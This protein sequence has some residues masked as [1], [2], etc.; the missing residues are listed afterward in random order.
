MTVCLSMVANSVDETTSQSIR[1]LFDFGSIDDLNSYCAKMLSALPYQ[2]RDCRLTTANSVWINSKINPSDGFVVDMGNSFSAP[3][4]IMNDDTSAAADEINR[5]CYDKTAGLIPSIVNASD[6]NACKA[7]IANA[8]YFNAK[9]NDPF[10]PEKTKSETFHGI[11][12]DAVVDMMH[13]SITGGYYKSDT[14]ESAVISY[15]DNAYSMIAVMPLPGNSLA[16]VAEN[17]S[18]DD[19]KTIFSHGKAHT[20]VLS[21]PKFDI[22][23]N[24]EYEETIESMGASLSNVGLDGLTNHRFNDPL[25]VKIL[26]NAKIK[27]DEEG[28]VAAAVTG[29]LTDV[30]GSMPSTVDFTLDRPFIYL[31]RNTKTGSIIMMGQYT[32]PQ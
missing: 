8:L 25:R 1:Q 24:E 23:T 17:I 27:V 9:W 3:V 15:K 14:W 10:E 7:F 18:A 29:A 21:M 22:S 16:E 19:I 6:L 30:T 12:S 11:E 13:N 2:S 31:I 26:Q 32:Q 28:T 5:W 4:S 20:I